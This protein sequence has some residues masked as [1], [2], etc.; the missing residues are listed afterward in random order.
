MYLCAYLSTSTSAHIAHWSH[1]VSWT[2][3]YISDG[4]KLESMRHAFQAQVEQNPKFKF[5]VEIPRSPKHTLLLNK[6]NGNNVWEESM[7]KELGSFNEQ[8]TFRVIENGEF[9]SREYK[10]IPYHIIF[11][12]KFDLRRKSRL[13]AGGNWC[14]PPK[15]MFTQAS[16]PWILS[17][18]DSCLVQWTGYQT[19]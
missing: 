11:D 17:G 14:G 5:G 8:K 10:R 7:Q 19:A 4:Q 12:V 15:Q 2:K 3:A 16:W 9:L 18:L 6:V 1:V 13:V